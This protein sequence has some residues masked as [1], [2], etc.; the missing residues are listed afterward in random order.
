MR[1]PTSKQRRL[2]ILL[3][4]VITFSLAYYAGHT[5]KGGHEGLPEINGVLITP[6][7]PLSPINLLNQHGE[8]FS[9]T[10]MQGHW[11]LLML[12]PG[13]GPG[14]NKIAPI[15]LTQLIQVHNRLAANPDLQQQIHYH[16]L[17]REKIE[18]GVIS[19]ASISDN[20]QTLHGDIAQVNKTF[21]TLGGYTEDNQSTLYL[22]GP[23]TK[24][25]ALFTQNSNTATIAEDL[26]NLITALP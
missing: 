5:Q 19:F 26:I 23:E 4:V 16:Y 10:D 22:I 18:N 24:L 6:P 9:L 17:A 21:E 1:R 20:F 15:A 25:H 11:N 2:V 14:P 8:A 7:F 13:P 3:L 12:D